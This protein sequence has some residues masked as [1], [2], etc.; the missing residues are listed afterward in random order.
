MEMVVGIIM[1]CLIIKENYENISFK[2][3][4]IFEIE[5]LYI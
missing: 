5:F 4:R 1:D 3:F 2:S